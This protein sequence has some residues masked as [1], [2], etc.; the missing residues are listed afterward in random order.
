MCVRAC[1]EATFMCVCV[2]LYLIFNISHFLFEFS[3]LFF[4]LF[5]FSLRFQNLFLNL[6]V[7]SM[8]LSMFANSML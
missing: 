3:A 2:F 8:M 4:F 7:F 1:F 5:F 6:V